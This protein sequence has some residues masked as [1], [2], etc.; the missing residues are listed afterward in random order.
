MFAAASENV[1]ALAL[2]SGWTSMSNASYVPTETSGGGTY[3]T[4]SCTLGYSWYPSYSYPV[5]IT[6]PAR[7]I[8]LTLSEIEKLRKLARGDKAVQAILEKFTDQIEIA[9]DF[10]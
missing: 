5:Y 9:V 1:Q 6:S 7:P 3:T 8:K 2:T 4:G 10:K